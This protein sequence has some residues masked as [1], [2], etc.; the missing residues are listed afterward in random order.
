MEQTLA[1]LYN[2]GEEDLLKEILDNS[3]IKECKNG[4]KYF[5]LNN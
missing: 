2:S 5:I 4:S 3:T 1:L